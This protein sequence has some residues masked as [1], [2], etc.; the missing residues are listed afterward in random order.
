MDNAFLLTY[1]VPVPYEN[2]SVLSMFKWFS[3][4]DEMKDFVGNMRS[5]YGEKFIIGEALEILDDRQIEM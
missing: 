3:S 4:E 1:A 2:V 5:Q